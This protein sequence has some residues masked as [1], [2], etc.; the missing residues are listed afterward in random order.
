[1]VRKHATGAPRQRRR[2]QPGGRGVG[3]RRGPVPTTIRSAAWYGL[4]NGMRGRFGNDVP[5]VLETLGLAEVEDNAPTTACGPCSDPLGQALG[6]I[7]RVVVAGA[8]L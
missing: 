6:V 3:S 7:E 8:S 5:P 2:A 1:M 4:K